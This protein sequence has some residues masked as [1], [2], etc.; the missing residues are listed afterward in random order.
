MFVHII[1][2]FTSLIFGGVGKMISGQ[3]FTFLFFISLLAVSI[4]N[5]KVLVVV[6]MFLD[7]DK[8]LN[9][10]SSKYFIYIYIYILI[11]QIV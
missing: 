11:I 9:N 8:Y 10:C 4:Q 1:F 2:T 5:I 6:K 7:L 3:F